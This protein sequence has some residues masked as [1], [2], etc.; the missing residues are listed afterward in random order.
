MPEKMDGKIII[1]NTTTQDDVAFF[2]K[3]GVRFLVTTT[4]VYDGRSFGTNMMEAAI[5]AATGRKEPIDYANPGDYFLWMEQKI[6]E[7]NLTLQVQ[8]LNA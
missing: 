5:I 8:E 2:K 1:T 7:L 4:P 6:K 3:C